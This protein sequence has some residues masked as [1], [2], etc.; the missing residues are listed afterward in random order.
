MSLNKIVFCYFLLSTFGLIAQ[1]HVYTFEEFKHEQNL[2]QKAV[3]G[4]QL[5][6]DY[7]RNDLDSLKIVS[8][9]LLLE[10]GS[11][12]DNFAIAVGKRNLGSH[13]IRTGDIAKGIINLKEAS[14]LFSKEEDYQLLTETYNE[15][16][17]AYI[18]KG[19]PAD[20]IIWFEKSLKSG[21]QS[22]D[23][24]SEFLAKG[25]Y[26]QALL[27][28]G[29]TEKAKKLASEY[30]DQSKK[31]NKKEA[32][33]IANTI[34]GMIAMDA[35][36]MDEGISYY[37]Q[38]V[39]LYLEVGSK[40]QAA[41][42]YNNLAIIYFQEGKREEALLNFEK[43]LNLRME[44][45]N[46]SL[47]S[48]S[49]YNI[50]SYY[51]EINN[52]DAAI[53]AFTDAYNVGIEN[54]AKKDA[55]D[56]LLSLVEIYK[57][58]GLTD[59]ALKFQEEYSALLLAMKITDKSETDEG[60]EFDVEFEKDR[61]KEQYDRREKVLKGQIEK[62]NRIQ[63]LLYGILILLLICI[64]FLVVKNRRKINSSDK[65]RSTEISE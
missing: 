35:G 20:A 2:R 59:K 16:G 3:I 8:R 5:W 18:I 24:T 63:Y 10:A 22:F 41:N 37:N 15:I 48:E 45:K 44:V 52:Y 33:A 49:Y 29:K 11:S 34:L 43:A 56:A 54:E 60:H 6:N 32:M 25:N 13:Q 62:E 40:T 4:C 14:E 7:L 31:Q 64:T 12:G 36:M 26:A 46:A 58:K 39:R 65:D 50:G 61:L 47:V 42:A 21:K 19:D 51:L 1:Q 53:D 28:M 9:L 27:R 57:L 17:N 38:S 30:L 23:P 55:A